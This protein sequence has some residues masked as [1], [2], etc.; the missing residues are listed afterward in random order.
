MIVLKNLILRSYQRA[1][2]E[3]AAKANTLVVLPTG[4]GKTAI[5]IA[6][7]AARLTELGGKALVLAPTKPLA[8]QHLKSFR[9][10]LELEP[11][12]IS[13]LTGAIPLSK[14][15]ELWFS[16][17]VIIATPQTVVSELR[18]G[19]SRLR[20]VVVLVIDEC[21]HSRQRYANTVI[22]RRYLAEAA[23]PRILALT[24]SPGGESARIAEIKENLGIEAIEIRSHSDPDV[25]AYV[26]PRETIYINVELG[27]ELCAL[28]DGFRR[29]Y[30]ESVREL[31]KFGL[32]KPSSGVTKR[33]ILELQSRLVAMRTPA[34]YYGLSIA[35]RALK[36]SHAIELLETQ[37][38]TALKAYL[39]RLAQD[40]S[41]AA[42][43][44]LSNPSFRAL[45]N[46]VSSLSGS[47]H[48]KQA[49]LSKLVLEQL[50]AK[51]GRKALVFV[52][53]RQTVDELVE[54]LSTLPGIS[55]A[56]LIGQREGMSQR[57]QLAVLEAFATGQ[58]N[59][60]VATSIGEEG[61]DIVDVPIAIFYDSVPSEIRAIQRSGRVGRLR[62]GRIYFL[63]TRNSRDQAYHWAARRK[64]SKMK[65]TL[66]SMG[67][68]LRG[69]RW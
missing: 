43:G 45:S 4:L 12:A 56:K 54:L 16:S 13:L 28:R 7:V 24:A 46:A 17:K 67:Q 47:L 2:F 9:A 59:V 51:P 41:R 66:R 35:S 33:E 34:S 10:H 22:A 64:E 55:P 21:H 27:K 8:A 42:A 30:L 52:N 6:L 39:E 31:R 29:L 15:A 53:F 65:S 32:T 58:Y 63:L 3:S 26:Q 57:Q 5:A 19:R 14:R 20:D 48:P 23:S 1:I 62:P 38:V 18:A 40:N 37:S 68:A 60:L 36:L 69:K 11:D 44:L 25:A 50:S 49:A 61:L